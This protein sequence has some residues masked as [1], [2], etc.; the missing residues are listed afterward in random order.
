[1]EHTRSGRTIAVKNHG[2]KEYESAE[3]VIMVLRNPYDA[4][5]ADYKRQMSG[6]HTG[7]IEKKDFENEIWRKFTDQHMHR[8]FG[9][10]VW[11][12][13]FAQKAK[14]PML[15]I[16]YED[17]KENLVKEMR[18][19]VEFYRDN[20]NIP[21]PD[22]EHRLE[23]LLK[24][25]VKFHRKKTDLGDIWPADKIPQ[26]DNGIREMQ[27]YYKHNKLPEMPD[28][29]LKEP[30]KTENLPS[31]HLQMT[32]V[33]S[34][35]I[36]KVDDTVRKRELFMQNGQQYVFTTADQFRVKTD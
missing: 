23:C 1:M 16:Y 31:E 27:A 13:M 7:N 15:I 30:E 35:A 6:S 20:F 14:I 10:A 34:H 29:Y 28:S 18:K 3:G 24:Q 26:L 17:M 32:V 2:Q 11:F 5:L 21:L 12:P 4:T 8:W 22:A 19:V 25:E 33:N 36:K 9:S